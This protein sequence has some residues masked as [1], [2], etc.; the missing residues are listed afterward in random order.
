[1]GK[2]EKMLGFG[3]VDSDLSDYDQITI[4][5]VTYSV[6][7]IVD[8]NLVAEG[9]VPLYLGSD[10]KNPFYTVASGSVIGKVLSYIKASDATGQRA[11]GALLMFVNSVGTYFYVKADSAI[12]NTDLQNNQGAMTVSDE[13]KALQDEQ[14]KENDP[15]LYYAKKIG[16]PLLVTGVSVYAGV[17]VV[18]ALIARKQN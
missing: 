3:S 14:A 12:S 16:L 17:Q 5:G 8:K 13:Q 4:N 18:K 10:F 2:V 11:G 6:N 15:I 1:M 7:Q 9:N